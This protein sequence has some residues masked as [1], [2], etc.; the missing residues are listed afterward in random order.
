MQRA[1]WYTLSFLAIGAPAFSQGRFANFETPQTHPIEIAA[2]G[3]MEYVLVCNTPDNSVEIYEAAPPHAFVQR[4]PVGMGPCT[5]RWNRGHG[6]FYTCNFDGDS[7]S[8]VRLE[9]SRGAGI[10]AVLERTDSFSIGDGPSDIAFDPT[11]TTAAVSLSGLSAVVYVDALDLTPAGGESRLSIADPDSGLPFAVKMPR[12]ITWLPD[13]RFFVANLRGGSPD[14]AASSA[15]YDVGLYRFDPGAPIQPD[16]ASGLGSTNHAFAISA[17][18]ER[19]FLVGTKAQNHSAAGVQAVSQLETG[20]VQSW[21]MVVDIPVGRPM[22]VRR[23]A[24][25]FPA[26]PALSLL[27]PVPTLQ[28]INLNRDYRSV[29]L[30]AV[31][32]DDALVQPTDIVLIEDSNGVLER[33]VLTCFHSDRIGVLVPDT[34]S[35]GGYAI[36]RIDVPVLSPGSLYSVVGPRGLAYSSRHGLIFTNGRLD[37][38]LAVIDP[39]SGTITSHFQL[40]NDP[41]PDVIREGRQFLYSNRFSIDD[42]A[43]P[44]KT[45]GFVSCAACHVDARTDGIPWDLGSATA[46]PLIPSEFHDGTGEDT[47]SMPEFP[48]DKGPM[49]TQTLQ[50]LVNYLLNEEFQAVATNAPY[51]W[52]GDK[53]D[54]TDFNEA[55]VNLQGMDDISGIL[56][57]KGITDGEMKAYRRFVNTILHPPNPE[58]NLLRITTGTLGPDPND[59]LRAS[60]AKLGMMLFHDIPI[61]VTRG[62][63]DCHQLP[64]GSTNT[65]SLT[66]PVGSLPHPFESTSLRNVRLRE[67][68]LN[69]GFTG[70]ISEFTANNGLLHPGDFQFLSSFSINTFIHN[71]FQTQ[72]PGPSAADVDQQL[73]ALTEF[74]RQ[75]DTGT[76]PLAGFAY[77]VDPTLA[78]LNSGLN[79]IV[80]KRLES[81]VDEANVGLA[82][83]ARNLGIEKGFWFDV[84]A[85]PPIYVEE[86]TTNLL[87]REQVLALTSGNDNVVIAQGT[88]LGTERRRASSSGTATGLTG[89]TPAN[90]TLEAMAPNTAYVDVSLFDQHLGLSQPPDTS[91][92]TLRTLQ[93]SVLG[94]FGVPPVLRHEPPR[95]FRITAD[96]VLPGAQLLFAM[97]AG[98]NPEELPVEIMVMDLYPTKYTSG[99]R[100]IWETRVELD[101][102]QSFALLNGGYWAPSVS[103]VLHRTTPTPNLQPTLWNHFLV[104]I[105][106]EDGQTGF[107][108]TNWQTLTIQSER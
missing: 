10:K 62:C 15:Q 55:F 32:T 60:G 58:Q 80:L 87:T 38:T 77:T 9:P 26:I 99:G 11:N 76:A 52:R 34:I 12:A 17:D 95:R 73:E 107:D 71:V 31:A 27:L 86:G 18:G 56:D 78:P 66:F 23:E 45:G 102:T 54:F 70:S 100:Q 97:A 7:V 25:P 40:Q 63:V 43:L 16:F 51:H 106:N 53:A 92:W 28:S 59:P 93:Q 48:E 2:V 3:G 104:G 75:F 35:P 20:F 44:V 29:L 108:L 46:G 105:R 19:L 49:M 39:V 22:S 94:L 37:N 64:D 98:P 85:T 101:A 79:K 103:D 33:I 69:D 88:P 30:A 67:M 84:T 57:P 82:V 41:T 81:Q 65:S 74:V 90:V 72:M 91:I 21:L 4:V 36:E 13:G 68:A 8:I 47:S 6:R 5:V 1:S 83:Y 24:P 50:G 89:P 61:V 14:P 42:S 96:N